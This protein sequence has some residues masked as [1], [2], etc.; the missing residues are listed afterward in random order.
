MLA[1]SGRS[2]IYGIAGVLAK[3]HSQVLSPALIDAK[4]GPIDLPR[5]VAEQCICGGMKVQCGSNHHQQRRLG[6]D[7]SARKVSK[8]VKFIPL[9]VPNDSGP[10]VNALQGK[11]D[12]FVRF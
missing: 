1:A 5:N 10:V 3:Y 2:S 7:R 6:G 9:L 4:D 11:M 8:L 12:V